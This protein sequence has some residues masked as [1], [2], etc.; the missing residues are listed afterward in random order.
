MNKNKLITKVM[1]HL[2]S[3]LLEAQT[4]AENAHKA[5]TD[6]Q[7]VAETQYDTLAIESAYL[8]EGQSRRILEFKLAIQAYENLVLQSFTDEDAI[9]LSA[10]VQLAAD[11]LQKH[12]FFIGPKN[13]GFRIDI[14]DEVVTI[15]TPLSPMGKALV[16]KYVEDEITLQRGKN[17]MKDSVIRIY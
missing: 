3:Q 13:G 5:A 15:I 10:M 14:D 11:K 17:K 1:E 7:S 4:A 8:A 2:T 12:W 16:G 9:A 6:E